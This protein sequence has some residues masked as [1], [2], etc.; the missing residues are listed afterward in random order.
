M[1]TKLLTPADLAAIMVVETACHSHPWSE[2]TMVSCLEGRYFNL[3]LLDDGKL[4]AFYIAEQAG[5][6]ISLMDICVA[7]SHQGRG[8]AKRLMQDLEDKALAR[9]GESIFL[10]VRASNQSAIGLYHG[11][12][13][14][15]M[16]VRKNYYP[17]QNGREDA[18]LMG[19]TL[20]L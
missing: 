13:Y 8:L 3:G 16:G 10:E 11:C 4:I 5:P 12:G 9:G 2:K 19:F 15:E 20:G 7:P 18:L 14:A 17:A 6:D 1:E